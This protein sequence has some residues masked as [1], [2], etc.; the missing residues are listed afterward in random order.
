MWMPIRIMTTGLGKYVDFV[1]KI[2][3]WLQIQVFGCSRI[4]PRVLKTKN[5]N[6]YKKMY[7][8]PGRTNNLQK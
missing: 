7:A 2:C 3:I 5:V 1:A 8:N 4:I 6:I